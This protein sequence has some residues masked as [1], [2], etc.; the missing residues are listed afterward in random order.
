MAP[1]QKRQESKTLSKKDKNLYAI[2]HAG[3]IQGPEA[4]EFKLETTNN[5]KK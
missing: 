5:P 4:C 2:R 3:S 1:I